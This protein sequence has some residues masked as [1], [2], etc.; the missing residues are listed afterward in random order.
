MRAERAKYVETF[1]LVKISTKT[2]S[3][4]IFRLFLSAPR[5]AAFWTL[6]RAAKIV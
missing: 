1:F 4:K 5:G 2:T 3:E 6:L